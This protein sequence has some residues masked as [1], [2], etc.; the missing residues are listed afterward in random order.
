MGVHGPHYS[1]GGAECLG[2]TC[3]GSGS[4]DFFKASF[5]GRI[6]KVLYSQIKSL[7]R[8]EEPSS[9]TSSVCL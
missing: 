6:N 5:L 3:M 8:Y 9:G 2:S 1:N 7:D 4:G